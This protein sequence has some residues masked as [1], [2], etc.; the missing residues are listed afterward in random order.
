MSKQLLHQLE[1]KAQSQVPPVG[2]I[3]SVMGPPSNF[4]T[5]ITSAQSSKPSIT[6]WGI[7]SVTCHLIPKQLLHQLELKANCHPRGK[8]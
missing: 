6:H 1:L 8:E 2:Q 3:L 4:L 7:L 5:I